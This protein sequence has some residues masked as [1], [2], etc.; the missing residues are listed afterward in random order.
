M[1]RRIRN[2]DV[3]ATL[4]ALD[5]VGKPYAWG[6]TDCGSL[7][8]SL[9]SEIYGEPLLEDCRYDSIFGAMAVHERTGGALAALTALGAAPLELRAYANTGD[10]LI[11]P[12]REDEPFD[13]VMPVITDR[14]LFTE[15][16]GLVQLLP[17]AAA[18]ADALPY[19]LPYEW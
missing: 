2:W 12:P 6:E 19:R 17:L 7:Y 14:Y 4:W 9:L 10:V 15:P 16:D 13:A 5:Q 1:P 3:Q 11:A 18:P 8:L